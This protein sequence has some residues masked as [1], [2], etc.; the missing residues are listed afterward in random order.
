M[1]LVPHVGNKFSTKVTVVYNE[2]YIQLDVSYRE[3]LEPMKL[4]LRK[5]KK[6]EGSS[7]NLLPN[8]EYEFDHLFYRKRALNIK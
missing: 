4:K 5:R 2:L 1:E 3:N 6:S 7:S 8:F